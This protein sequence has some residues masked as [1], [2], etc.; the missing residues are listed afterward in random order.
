MKKR[1]VTIKDVAN[2]AGVSV[3]TVSRVLA[4]TV[5]VKQPLQERVNRSIA[6]LA[7]K[8][9]LAARALRANHVNIIGLM[10]PDITNPYFSQIA[11]VLEH[12]ASKRGYALILA[13]SHSDMEHEAQQFSA[14]LDHSPTGIVLIPTCDSIAIKI[15]RELRIAILDRPLS[16]MKAISLDQE[17]SSALAADH[18]FELGHRKIAYI[19]GPHDVRASIEREAG[20]SRRLRELQSVDS[21]VELTVFNGL[22]DYASGED[23]ARGILFSQASER[24]TAIAAAS[25]QQAI[26]ALRAARDLGIS[27][28]NELSI[29][30]FDDIVLAN[31]LVPRLTTI[32]QP[33][34]EMAI[35]ALDQI[36]GSEDVINDRRFM[37]EL[38]VRS[39]TTSRFESGS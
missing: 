21:S 34:R 39:S 16:G 6:K 19:A 17:Q 28:P 32:R 22:F 2:D 26:G 24:P 1:K 8:P 29:V 3:G 25:D 5:E 15:P 18:L 35:E 23:I 38:V 14:L 9:N 27:V 13:S 20:F 31:L 7:Y 37:A 36:L 12:E 30:G 33:V 4:K 11:N 10:V